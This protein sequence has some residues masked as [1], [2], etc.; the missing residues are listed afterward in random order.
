MRN[1]VVRDNTVSA[2]SADGSATIAGAG[3]T[4]AG[5]LE[6]HNVVVSGNSGNA[7]GTSGSALGG[8]IW[9]GR[10][11]APEGPIPSLL[12]DNTLV[13]RN[14]L[15]ASPGLSVQGG[16]LYTAGFAVTLTNSLI[17]RNSPDQCFG[18]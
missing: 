10:P 18:C 5:A 11:F 3:I 8:G 17:A 7:A 9:N 6:L 15:S 4:N 1:S 14:T 12:L 2:S 13:T 16:G